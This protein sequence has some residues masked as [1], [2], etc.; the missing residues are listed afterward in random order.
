MKLPTGET[1]LLL[2]KQPTLSVNCEKVWTMCFFCF[3]L[4]CFVKEVSVCTVRLI[5]TPLAEKL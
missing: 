3:V 1:S 4:F 5:V 2:P